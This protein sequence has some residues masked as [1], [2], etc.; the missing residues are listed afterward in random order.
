MS[1][2]TEIPQVPPPA[3]TVV[4]A[5]PAELVY[6]PEEPGRRRWPVPVIAG[7]AALILVV[8]GVCAL[9]SWRHG[10]A[11]QR[12]AQQQEARA[13]TAERRA[14]DLRKQLNASE[15]DVARLQQRTN[16][17]ANEKAQAEDEREI[18]R[19]TAKQ[20]GQLTARAD[21]VSAELTGCI[22]A[23][24]GSMGAPDAGSLDLAL[25]TCE[26]ALDDYA[27][28]EALIDGISPPGTR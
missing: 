1:D 20:Y 21:A 16:A 10:A 24:A 4:V 11:W 2:A 26:R 15:A 19:V 8:T 12:R 27:A 28:L 5:R 6:A 25:D 3:P 14:G 7:I 23:L 13:L 22:G 9:V 17:L 18:L